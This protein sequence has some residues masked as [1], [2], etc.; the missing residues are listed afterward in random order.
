MPTLDMKGP[1]KFDLDTIKKSVVSDL[2]GNY[3]LGYLRN[4]LFVVRYVGRADDQPVRDRIIQ[5]LNDGIEE[6]KYFK[7]SYDA[8]Q[9]NRFYKECKNYHDFGGNKNLLN[10]AH[11]DVPDGTNLK[12]PYCLEIK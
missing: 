7:F 1:F 12:C 11:P 6:Y 8:N 9:T 4:G 5:H 10:K 3:A 2:P